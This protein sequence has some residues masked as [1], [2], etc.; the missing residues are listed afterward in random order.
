[1][2]AP[3]VRRFN[4]HDVKWT[5][6]PEFGGHEA[7]L[8]Q[9][10]DG[11]W[12]AG[13]YKFSG[14]YSWRMKYDDNFYVIAGTARILIDGLEPFMVAPGDFCHIPQ[15]T[16]VTFEMSEDFHEISVLVADKPF[17]HREK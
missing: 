1:M 15:G 9:S 14:T 13:T 5:P 6:F 17:D 4:V 2:T 11:M 10:E 8:H 16:E 12:T 7:I 3:D